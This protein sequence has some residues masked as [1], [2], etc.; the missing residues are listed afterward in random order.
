MEVEIDVNIYL[1]LRI[2]VEVATMK[3]KPAEM[4]LGKIF[5]L[6]SKIM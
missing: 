6:T 2:V 3:G 1:P 4:S 5:S